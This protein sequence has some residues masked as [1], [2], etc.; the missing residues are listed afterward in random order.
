MAYYIHIHYIT[1]YVSNTILIESIL[2]CMGQYIIK[3][4]G[5]VFSKKV[6]INLSLMGFVCVTCVFHMQIHY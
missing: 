4:S 5:I 3:K 2:A 1:V 6:D